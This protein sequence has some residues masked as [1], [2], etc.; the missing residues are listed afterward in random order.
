VRPVPTRRTGLVAVGVAVV[1]LL[2]PTDGVLRP[3]AL[4]NAALLVL[5]LV[6]VALAVDPRRIEVER[7]L[8]PVIALRGTGELTWRLRNPTDRTVHVAMA[9]ELAPSLRAS[10]RRLRGTLPGGAILRTTAVLRPSRRGR[11][12]IGGVVARV[13]GPLRL[14]AR[15]RRLAV[16]GL[17]RVHPAFPSR[18]EAELRITRARILEVG[19]RSAKGR[20]GGTEFDQLRE[21]GVDDEVR[22]IDWAATARAGKAMVRTYRAERNQNVL[23]LLDNGR[24]MAGQVADVPRVEHAMDALMC[25]TTVATRLGDRCGLVAFDRTVRAVLPARSGR[26]QLGR[27]AEAMFDLEPVLAESDYR[28]AFTHALARFRRRAMIVLFTDLVEQAVGESLLPALPLLVRHHIVLIAAVRD[29]DVVDWATAPPDDATEA[30]RSAAATLALAERE[31]A[32][33]RLRSLGA[34]V[35]DAPPSQLAPNLADTYLELKARG[36]L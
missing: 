36:G 24:V 23:L 2:L 1:V 7:S 14:G 16:P 3:L 12:E 18:E 35:I 10:T 32:I 11:F 6:D 25:L 26:D 27:M 33:A 9:D 34:I 20:G 21:Y 31:R 28:G 15:Q 5:V 17:L 8:P 30:Y 13:D 29:P 22:R 19:L 4:A